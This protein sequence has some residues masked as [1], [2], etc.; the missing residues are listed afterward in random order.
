MI[1]KLYFFVFILFFSEAS[2]FAAA[3]FEAG[4]EAKV[5]GVHNSTGVVVTGRSPVFSWAYASGISS[6]TVTVSSDNA[7]SAAGELWNFIGTTTTANSINYVTRVKYNEDGAAQALV[8][9]GTYFWEVTIYEDGTSA[10]QDDLFYAVGSSIILARSKLDLAVDWNNPFNP[11]TGQ[12]TIFRFSAKDRDRKVQLRVFTLN[13]MLV[14]EWPEQTAL[15]DAWYSQS[16]DGKNEDGD[17]VARGIYLVNLKDMGEE[18]SVT[19]KV[20]VIKK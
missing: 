18:E 1:K 11:A 14:K 6:F 3:T 13:G 20:V 4:T 17:I 2:L 12:Y 9:G 19:R 8:P 7:Y 16:W 10:F 5:D 15:K